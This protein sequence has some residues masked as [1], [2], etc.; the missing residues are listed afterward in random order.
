MATES[1]PLDLLEEPVLTRLADRLVDEAAAL[2]GSAPA[3][4][5]IDLD[6]HCLR[7]VAGDERLPSEVA[8]TQL[9]GPEIPAPQALGLERSVPCA[10]VVP[11]W[12]RGRALAVL[13]F[14]TE[15]KGDL[16]VLS[17]RGA[18][19]LELAERYTDVFATA[20]RQREPSAAAELQQELLPPR[21]THVEGAELAS[22]ILPAYDVG[23]DWMD[24]CAMPD[25]AW[26]AVA[27]AVGKGTQAAAISAIALAAYRATRRAG[28]SLADA[29]AHMHQAICALEVEGAFLTAVLASWDGSARSLTWLRCGHPSP[30][31]WHPERGLRTLEGGDGPML[32]L[33]QLDP[34][35]EPAT[36]TIEPDELLVVISDGV[37]ERTT[38]G[39]GRFGEDGLERALAAARDRTA[40]AAVSAVLSAVG[41]VDDGPLRDDASIVVLAPQAA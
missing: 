32:G 31:V 11:L 36:V 33:E 22:A 13:M 9:V 25:G 2:A 5:V 10:A 23:G 18:A 15:P 34:P 40:P 39:N 17:T 20:R 24:H 41:G 30:L 7:R 27:D 35:R 3:L 37:V 28:G 16:S 26:L 6:G 14:V 19:A 1:D 38:L 21:L 12:L 8:T 29:A 4:Y